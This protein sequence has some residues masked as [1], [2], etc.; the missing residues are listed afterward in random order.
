MKKIGLSFLLI[1]SVICNAEL[2]PLSE[3]DLSQLRG[4]ASQPVAVS[5]STS[6]TTNPSAISTATRAFQPLQAQTSNTPSAG[7]T[8]D[9]DLQMHIDEIRWVDTDGAGINGTQGAVIMKGFSVGHL[10]DPMNPAPAQ[11]RGVTLDVDGRDGLSIG[12][13]QI[14][15]AQGN[16]IDLYIDSVQIR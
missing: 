4:Q 16:G 14:G 3:D 15:D 12:I 9:I 5:A 11:I 6:A 1:N 7:I 10:D 13:N 8:I 2:T